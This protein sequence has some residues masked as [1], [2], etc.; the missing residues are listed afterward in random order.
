MITTLRTTSINAD[1]CRLID[2]LNKELHV[3]YGAQQE[4]FN[5]FN[6][7]DT[8]RY[9]LVAYDGNEPVGTGAI[10]QYSNDTMEVKRMFVP[11]ERRGGGI[12]SIVLKELEQWSRE[13]NYK[14]CILETGSKLPEAVR[15]YRNHGYNQIANYGQYAGVADS[16]CFEKWL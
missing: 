15:L 12:A 11:V 16:I 5:Q 14:R 13:M 1:F 3:R 4:F 9:A 7:L 8:I 2:E 10:R 6:K